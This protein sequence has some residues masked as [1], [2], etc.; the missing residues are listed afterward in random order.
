M[1][2]GP[3]VALLLVDALAE[4]PALLGYHY[5]PG[6][7][8]DLLERLGRTDEARA[9]FERAAASTANERERASLL[10][11]ARRSGQAA[12]AEPRPGGI[13]APTS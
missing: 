11:Q 4:A 8:A 7:R 9:E 13:P 1:A 5:V 3:A 10:A 2:D 6:V 12:P